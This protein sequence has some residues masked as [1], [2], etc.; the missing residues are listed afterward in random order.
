M[1]DTV[2]E[3]FPGTSDAVRASE[4]VPIVGVL[5]GAAEANLLNVVVVGREMNGGLFVASSHDVDKSLA[6]LARAMAQMAMSEDRG[7]FDDSE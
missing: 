4:V 7:L 2:T 1:S 6:L 5:K 3:L